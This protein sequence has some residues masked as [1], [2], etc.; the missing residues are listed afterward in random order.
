[1]QTSGKATDREAAA[2]EKGASKGYLLKIGKRKSWSHGP[3]GQ[4][5]KKKEEIFALTECPEESGG[6]KTKTSGKTLQILNK[7]KQRGSAK[8]GNSK[9]T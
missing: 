7:N 3:T 8:E 5:T 9:K 2:G 4:K 1:L 6:T